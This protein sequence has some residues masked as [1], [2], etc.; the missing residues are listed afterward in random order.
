MTWEQLNRLSAAEIK[1]LQNR[2]LREFV[3]H[4]LP[5]SPYYRALFERVGLSFSDIRNTDDL[6]QIPMSSKAELAPT[7][8]NRGRPREFILQPDE[9]LIKKY[10]A[11][12]T[13][14]KIAWG[15]V[16]KKD[17]KRQLEREYK[18]IHIHFTTGRTALPTPFVYSEYDLMLLKES[19]NRLLDVINVPRDAYAISGFPFSPHLAFW[20][21]YYATTTVGM[22]ALHT[23]GG[24]VFGTQKIM[25]GIERTKA[26]LLMFIPGYCYHLLREA[27]KQKRDFSSVRYIVLGGERV[28]AGFR[29]KIHELLGQLGA[30][31]VQIFTTY[32][33]TESK[34]AW[35]QCSETSGYHLYPDLG[36]FELIDKEGKRVA[37]DAGG[38]L[39]YTTLDWRGSV[40]VRYRT[41]DMA[42]GIEWSPC[43][44]CG[45]T[46]PR[47]LPDIQRSSDVKEFHLTKIKG[48]LVNLNAFYPLLSGMKS[49]EEW[50][51]E[52]GK[53]NNDPYEVDEIRIFV[54]PKSGQTFSAVS[55]EITKAVHEETGINPAITEKSLDELLQAMGMETELKEKRIVDSRSS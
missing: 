42:K 51:V 22:T 37:D 48:E 24:K 2:K 34:T 41:G 43:P 50:Q 20:L 33:M 54:A 49:V 13:L 53:K 8:E 26:S 39:V 3:R 6:Q 12:S 14:A 5:Y 11:K 32:A 21:A 10:A 4:Q 35:I 55:A 27:V 7:E 19:A 38:E 15:K 44:N 1:D 18:P 45:K 40:V 9:H 46:V 52:I 36:F 47:V 17:V 28:S 30:R 16:T 23:G 31:E 29:E 25:D